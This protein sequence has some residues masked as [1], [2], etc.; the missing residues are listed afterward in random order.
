M[1]NLIILTEI[2]NN[3]PIKNLKTKI[4]IYIAKMRLEGNMPKIIKELLKEEFLTNETSDDI[5]KYINEYINDTNKFGIL[6]RK[7]KATGVTSF[8][9]KEEFLKI[10]LQYAPY[11]QH[12]GLPF[13]KW[14]MQILSHYLY[15]KYNF[16]ICERTTEDV[17]KKHTASAKF[18]F[19]SVSS[20][21]LTHDYTVY[22]CLIRLLKLDNSTNEFSHYVPI[23]FSMDSEYS[24]NRMR[25]CETKAKKTSTFFNDVYHTLEATL[26][27]NVSSEKV[28]FLLSHTEHREELFRKHFLKS[29]TLPKA[30]YIF[31]NEQ[32]DLKTLSNHSNNKN[33]L[34][35]YK[36]YKFIRKDI[37]QVFANVTIESHINTLITN[38]LKIKQEQY[39]EKP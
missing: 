2:Y 30:T 32:K 13:F 14:D 26:P 25:F 22:F 28:L 18:P 4:D 15:L 31:L 27:K 33:L 29:K 9:K 5:K 6:M 35:F 3:F 7:Y 10:F 8:F 1:K 12:V 23:R 11:P 36:Y 17:L 24:T 20:G 19:L 16:A 34:T 37:N 21:Y 39:A 38:T